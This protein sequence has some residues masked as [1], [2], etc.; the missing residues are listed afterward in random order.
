MGEVGRVGLQQGQ[1]Q[2]DRDGGVHLQGRVPAGVRRRHARSYSSSR[3]QPPLTCAGFVLINSG[4]VE[5]PRRQGPPTPGGSAQAAGAAGA[6][7][8]AAAGVSSGSTAFF[9][10]ASAFAGTAGAGA[11]ACSAPSPPSG[12]AA[13]AGAGSAFTAAAP[14]A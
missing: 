13:A 6:A 14:L 12:P 2:G 7:S 5:V 3:P 4:A 8:G 10:A 1:E 9:K 11:G